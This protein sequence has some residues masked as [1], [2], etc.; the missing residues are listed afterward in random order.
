MYFYSSP[1]NCHTTSQ[2]LGQF[3]LQLMQINLGTWLIKF[4][5]MIK[6]NCKCNCK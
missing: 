1:K 2:M 3:I 5:D 4:L 6:N